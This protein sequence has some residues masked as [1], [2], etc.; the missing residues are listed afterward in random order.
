MQIQKDEIREKIITV[1]EIEFLN[2]GF[3]GASMRT[4]AKK[5]HTTLGNL[6]NYFENKEAIL[7]AVVG[8]VPE[9]IENMMAKHEKMEII[10]AMP[11]A[12]MLRQME[13]FAP[14][15]FG[16]DVLLS[17][18]FV[19]LME[20]CK[21]TKYEAYSKQFYE[22]ANTHVREHVG[23]GK[24]LLGETISHSFITALLFIGK[25]KANLEEGKKAL[26]KYMEVIILGVVASQGGEES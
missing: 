14:E 24:E 16:F 11:E 7:D 17:R 3:K 21:G 1:A 4:I 8:H 15:V 19:I 6:Y 25:H 9:A 2:K 26:I 20:G 5:A 22:I 18:P 12:E 13:R 10:Q 23:A